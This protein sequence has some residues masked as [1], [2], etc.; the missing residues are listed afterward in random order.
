MSSGECV[1]SEARRSYSQCDTYAP[2]AQGECSGR[3]S[4]NR[5]KSVQMAVVLSADEPD[6]LVLEQEDTMTSAAAMA[7]QV[8]RRSLSACTARMVA[9]R[10][11]PPQEA[12][13]DGEPGVDPAD[14]SLT[15]D[16]HGPATVGPKSSFA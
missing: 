13:G 10:S 15:G 8:S 2:G 5:P 11:L 6:V 4:S 1:G 9:R 7:A 3:T 12:I 14:R 16:L